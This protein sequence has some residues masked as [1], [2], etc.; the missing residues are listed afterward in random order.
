MSDEVYVFSAAYSMIE[1]P[2]DPATEAI[3]YSLFNATDMTATLID[4]ALFGGMGLKM[5]R[6]LKYAQNNYSGCLPTM[7]ITNKAYVTFI[8]DAGSETPE[9]T[10]TT[11]VSSVIDSSKDFLPFLQVRRENVDITSDVYDGTN[12]HTHA[13]AI[14]RKLGISYSS[15]GTQLNENPD[16]DDVDNA[17]IMCC[18]PLNSD[19]DEANIYLAEFFAMLAEIG[20]V[21]YTLGDDD[22]S[23]D[24]YTIVKFTALDIVI[25]LRYNSIYT[26]TVTGSIGSVNTVT[27]EY[28]N[29]DAG[30][31]LDTTTDGSQF[32]IK[33][34][35]TDATYE[36]ITVNGMMHINE[37]EGRW[38][39]TR[40][41][42][43]DNGDDD[44]SNSFL[45][46]ID[47]SLLDD[48]SLLKLNMV[49]QDGL[50]IVLNGYEY[51]SLAWYESSWFK[52]LF[53]AV[54]MVISAVSMQSWIAGLAT[55]F[56]TGG[57]TALLMALLEQLF[58]SLVLTVGFQYAA[59]AVGSEWLLAAAALLALA[60]YGVSLSG[61]S[62][63][64]IGTEGMV[65]S[66][67]MLNLSSS[68]INGVDSYVDS[69]TELVSEESDAFHTLQ[70]EQA[71]L[72]ETTANLLDSDSLLSPYN[73]V[74]DTVTSTA[75]NVT[76]M[77]TPSD[78]IH[79]TIHAGNIGVTVLDVIESYHDNMLS[80]PMLIDINT[81]IT[82]A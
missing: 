1:S 26:T 14:L 22:V 68:I 52:V 43:I 53:V 72:L 80:L 47:Y 28:L 58:I 10:K 54:I 63:A 62:S 75:D 16:I 3:L 78:F 61:Y 69:A 39:A 67:N 23:A 66:E 25:S 82:E 44:D 57:I 18:I 15:V 4:C 41:M 35:R 2:K 12:E 45:I 37:L 59:E 42:D 34:Q 29:V 27:K 49:L 19:L 50:Y 40:L 77:E 55:S 36:K 60:A 64:F 8:R 81:T 48:Y 5:R 9:D 24:N 38:V 31:D 32:I 73:F 65:T 13:S 79:R 11:T 17:Y 56:A 20:T 6:A 70:E 76:I 74:N 46:P 21:S 30:I 33:I 7:E 71:D 51:V